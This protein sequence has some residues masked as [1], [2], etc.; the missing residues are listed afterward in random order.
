MIKFLFVF[1][2][3][4]PCIA[5]FASAAESPEEVAHTYI[6]AMAD[7]RLTLVAD[8][9]HPAAL[10]RF[11]AMLAGIAEAITAAPP[12]RKPSPKLISALFGEGGVESVK[13]APARE[14]FVRFMRC[15]S[16]FAFSAWD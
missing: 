15:S 5:G 14:I 12:E 6:R 4:V 7:S 10:E 2:T 11:K 13:G 16:R 8:E 3:I 1:C 9:M